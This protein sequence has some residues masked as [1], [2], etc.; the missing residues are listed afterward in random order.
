MAF[1]A[2]MSLERKISGSMKNKYQADL[3]AEAGA[4]MISRAIADAIGTNSG[5]LVLA[6]NIDSSL[7]PIYYIQTG[8]N[9]SASNVLPL[10]SGDLT[11]YLSTRGTTPTALTN[12]L[13]QAKNTNSSN[14][15]NVNKMS[16][17][18]R[19]IANS[20]S[21]NL[22]A[23]WIYFTNSSGQ[24]NMR[25]AFFLL[26]EQSK[27]NLGQ[28]G[29][30]T[31]T[32]RAGWSN[33]PMRVPIALPG[34]TNLLDTNSAFIFASC[35]N[36]EPFVRNF[37]QLFSSRADYEAKKHL[38]TYVTGP[39]QDFIPSGFTN[40]N[41]SFSNY[42]QANLPKW[43]INYCATNAGFG[44]S[45]VIRASN[46]ANIININL[47]NFAKRDI[48]MSNGL[49]GKYFR[50]IERVASSI[51]DYIDT[52]SEVT[53]LSDASPTGEPAGKELAPL[54]ICVA[55][56]Y[57]WISEIG[58]ATAW[59]NK[60]TQTVFV[61][62]WNPYQMNISGNLSL[63]VINERGVEMAGSSGVALL[64]NIGNVT[65]SELKPNEVKVYQSGIATNTIVTSIRGSL[66]VANHPTLPLTA[67]DSILS[68]KHTRFE[69]RWNGFLFDRT[70][71]LAT[72][73][74]ANNPGLQ[75]S[76]VG[77]SAATRIK[78][79]GENR[80]AINYPSY[81]YL[82]PTKGY[83]SVGDPRQNFISPYDWEK[84]ASTNIEVLW[85]G[86]NNFTN[87]NSQ[88][89]N[90]NF[91]ARD[92]VRSSPLI[93]A[94]VNL[95]TL[96]PTSAPSNYTIA[97]AINAPF[98]IRNGS[99]ES[100]GEIGNIYDPAHIND[101][102]FSTSGSG[103][104]YASG[105]GRTLRIG[106]EE[107][108]YPRSDLTASGSEKKAPSWNSP[109]YRSA[110]LLDLFVV[111]KTNLN[112]ISTNNPKIN[113]NTASQDVLS[114]LFYNCS[115]NADLAFTNSI[116]T[117]SGA[118]NLASLVISNR[119]FYNLSDIYKITPRLLNPTN[120]YPALGADTST[121]IAAI[122]DAGREQILAS[123]L[124]LIDTQS[125]NF[126]VVSVGQAIGPTGKV[127][128]EAVYELTIIL[129][130]YPFTNGTG[131]VEYRTRVLKGH[132]KKY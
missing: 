33:D 71:I 116:L 64:P 23:P 96:D 28:H 89:Y 49:G 48:A 54:I 118:S 80:Y 1:M 122:N 132:S 20:G 126:K 82:D 75:K 5:F 102:G 32:N 125:R 62:I 98:H 60:V 110:Q 16:G 131:A 6:T 56:K 21:T 10:I 92:F 101:T 57:N 83:R 70:P 24:T 97:D 66:L 93:G 3:A 95:D 117:A 115:Q 120:Y 43:N 67:S 78:L 44:S 113:I 76:S 127:V 72:N 25:V 22:N 7:H 53:I 39:S 8:S 88:N 100:I 61:Q 45:S 46:I 37:A 69:A 119:P 111:G 18:Y 63:E 40:T 128:S 85:N 30:S 42:A 59:T 27:L 4:D 91:A 107:F 73:F 130:S 34:N 14:A 52:N 87:E 79:N 58:S 9:F 50:Y 84:P 36:K 29:W 114:A 108:E 105:G 12:Y 129:D 90:K 26:D 13:A 68:P 106:I 104:W 109:G 11:N 65:I 124:E 112:G 41:G 55:E 38:Y 121:N 17:G 86:R 31:N 77:G 103:S 15:L 47:P 99:M 35:V 19:I 2:S 123:I 94:L 51:V 81:G 74:F